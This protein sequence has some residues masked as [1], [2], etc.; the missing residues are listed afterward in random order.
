MP[1]SSLKTRA[2]ATDKGISDLAAGRAIKT[3]YTQFN[4]GRPFKI[5]QT[6]TKADSCV[7]VSKVADDFDFMRDPKARDFSQTVHEFHLRPNGQLLVGKSPK[8]D[9]TATLRTYGKKYDGNTI[10]A[11]L[12]N[13]LV[14]VGNEIYTFTLA[15]KEEIRFYTSPVGNSNVPYPL[16]VGTKNVYFLAE[17]KFLPY[18][19]F[20]PPPSP[21]TDMYGVL[22]GSGVRAQD[23]K[24]D[25]VVE[26]Q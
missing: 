6:I 12:K 24:I 2:R 19:S 7:K 10:L 18:D 25:V 17:K 22:Y 3:Y 15:P 21:T 8:S 9:M 4:G 11:V 20:T 23:M 13:K 5:T 26:P 16:L 1:R 14:F